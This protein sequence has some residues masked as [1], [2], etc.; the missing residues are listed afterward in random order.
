MP[1]GTDRSFHNSFTIGASSGK[2]WT[3][4]GGVYDFEAGSPIGL[5]VKVEDGRGGSVT[6]TFLT[7]LQDVAEPPSAP[8]TPTVKPAAGTICTENGTPLGTGLARIVPCAS[9]T[10][11]EADELTASFMDV[12]A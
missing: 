9:V 1:S 10:P 8:G 11:Q 6:H 3:K 12:P 2:L 7:G 4:E 5:R